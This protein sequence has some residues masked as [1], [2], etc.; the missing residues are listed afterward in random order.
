MN[1]SSRKR[2]GV[3]GARS[4]SRSVVALQVALETV[5]EYVPARSP[6]SVGPISLEIT[7]PSRDQRNEADRFGV[8]VSVKGE[9]SQG[10]VVVRETVS[11]PSTWTFAVGD[12]LMQPFKVLTTLTK[13]ATLSSAAEAVMA[14]PPGI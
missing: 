8:A 10:V 3:V 5:T 6:W 13:Y 1:A 9:P 14:C 7:A 2:P 4:I 11:A 12:C